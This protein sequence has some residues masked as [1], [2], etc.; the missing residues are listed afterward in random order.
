MVKL[1]LLQLLLCLFYDR[2]VPLLINFLILEQSF[3]RYIVILLSIEVYDLLLLIIVFGRCK[4]VNPQVSS[5][6]TVSEY[7]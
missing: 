7:N 3:G 4:T 5:T 6:L 1:E 2:V